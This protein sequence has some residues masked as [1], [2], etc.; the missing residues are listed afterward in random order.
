[1]I[2]RLIVQGT[3]LLGVAA[4]PWIF[5]VTPEERATVEQAV[6]RAGD[7]VVD[8][9]T[10][11]QLRDP[12]SAWRTARPG[13]R[14]DL[15]VDVELDGDEARLRLSYRG[16]RLE[17]DGPARAAV[18]GPGETWPLTLEAGTLRART[19]RGEIVA[20]APLGVWRGR[21]FGLEV[22][23]GRVRADAAEALRVSLD[24]GDREVAAG[25]T[26]RATRAGLVISEPGE[27]LDGGAP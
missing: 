3:L 14:I 8:E 5:P 17:L 2:G 23:P 9:A 24:Q 16:A 22:G 13:E 12:G 4:V 26:A 27:E 21:A 7:V 25:A 18:G 20:R 10:G 1:M 11:A 19:R 15:P 6:P